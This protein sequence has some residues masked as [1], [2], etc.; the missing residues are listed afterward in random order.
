MATPG[1]SSPADLDRVVVAVLVRQ[2]SILAEP[3]SWTRRALA[4]TLTSQGVHPL[5]QDA[6]RWSLSGALARALFEEL[7]PATGCEWERPYDL[8]QAR[9]RAAVPDGHPWTGAG[10]W[11]LDGFNDYPGTY[12]EDVLDLIDRALR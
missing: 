2:R 9:L 10:G 7:G 5:S 12:H 3:G 11:D 4:R 8:A 1:V 6:W